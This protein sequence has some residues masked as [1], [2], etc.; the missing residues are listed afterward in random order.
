MKKS[1]F[2]STIFSPLFSLPD[3]GGSGYAQD[4]EKMEANSLVGAHETPKLGVSTLLI[5]M[6][7]YKNQEE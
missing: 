6:N 5:K 3:H 4:R 2:I 1:C 7:D